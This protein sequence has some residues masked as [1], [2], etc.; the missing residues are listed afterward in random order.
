M[1]GEIAVRDATD[2]DAARDYF[3]QA[4]TLATDGGLRPLVALVHAGLGR[5][6]ARSGK[7]SDAD[8][9][10]TAARALWSE[11]RLGYRLDEA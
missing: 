4:M 8:A 3:D 9:H 11:M 1:L 2:G 10:F 6:A 7:R 5:V